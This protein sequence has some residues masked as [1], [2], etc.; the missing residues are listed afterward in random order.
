[1]ATFNLLAPHC[2]DKRQGALRVK[3]VQVSAMLAWGEYYKYQY[4]FGIGVKLNR[5]ARHNC[6]SAVSAVEQIE[7]AHRLIAFM[8]ATGCKPI[9]APTCPKSHQDIELLNYPDHLTYWHG[10]NDEPLV[11][12]EPYTSFE[13]IALEILMRGLTALVLPHPGIYG[14]GGGKTTSVILTSPC[15][16]GVLQQLAAVD[17]QKPLGEVADINWFEALNLGKVCKS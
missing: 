9:A 12:V 3:T 8:D 10:P 6:G 2:V 4:L 7:R 5:I 16:K 13:D 17:W 15:S 11:L 14:G 1:M